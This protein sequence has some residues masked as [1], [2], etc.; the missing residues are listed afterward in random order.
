MNCCSGGNGSSNGAEGSGLRLGDR[1]L[2]SL[3][4]TVPKGNDKESCFVIVIQKCLVTYGSDL[5]IIC[6]FFLHVC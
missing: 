4:F 6:L 5:P 1:S 2:T 3:S